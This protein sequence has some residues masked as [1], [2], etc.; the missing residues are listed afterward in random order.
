MPWSR[1]RA[2]RLVVAFLLYALSQRSALLSQNHT[3]PA[4]YQKHALADGVIEY[5]DEKIGVSFQAGSGWELNDAVRWQ[6]SGW[7]KST[8]PELATTV[9]LTQQPS[10]EVV[11]LY[12]R[13]FR[14]PARM[15]PNEIDKALGEAV[16][17]KISQRRKQGGLENYRV[18]ARSY[19]QSEV[20]GWRS[21]SCVAE[22]GDEKNRMIEYLVWIQ[23]ERTLAEFFIRAPESDLG[24]IRKQVDPIVES[25]RIP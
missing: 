15:T 13:V 12:Y 11:R 8:T 1:F 10:H 5:R 23:S 21:L 7:K 6:D 20:G 22:Y 18:R 17:D 24:R 19:E 2:L 9:E 14:Q 3:E 4:Q 25:L 16:D